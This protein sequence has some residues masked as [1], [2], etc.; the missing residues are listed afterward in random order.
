MLSRRFV[1][2]RA[3]TDWRDGGSGENR[4]VGGLDVAALLL[5]RSDPWPA[6]GRPCDGLW[7]SQSSPPSCAAA[8]SHN[9]RVGPDSEQGSTM[10]RVGG[11]WRNESCGSGLG[12]K[13]GTGHPMDEITRCP[14]CGKRLVP[15]VTIFGRTDL[16]CISC[17]DPGGK[18]AKSPPTS[19]ESPLVPE[20]RP[21]K[22]RG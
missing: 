12:W 2:V 8:T 16:Q 20:Y 1:L 17:D 4:A 15:I 22:R 14:K 19:P 21:V 7:I 6:V 11:T 13:I 10:D 9:Q 18:W 5:N 3:K